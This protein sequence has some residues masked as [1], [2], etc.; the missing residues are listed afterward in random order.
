MQ[1]QEVELDV[2]VKVYNSPLAGKVKLNPL[3]TKKQRELV[4]GKV[5][6]DDAEKNMEAVEKLFIEHGA[7]QEQFDKLSLPEVEFIL[8]DWLKAPK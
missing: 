1:E 5:D 7:T 2:V 8:K 4:A 3:S 6:E